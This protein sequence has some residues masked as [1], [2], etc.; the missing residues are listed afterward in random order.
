MSTINGVFFSPFSPTLTFLPEGVIVSFRNFPWGHNKNKIWGT[1]KLGWTQPAPQGVAFLV[2]EIL[3]GV[4]IKIR[5][6]VQT[7]WGG[8][9]CNGDKIDRKIVQIF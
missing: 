9:A 4:T 1:T 2:S 6:G 7:N 3:H 8:I 5:F